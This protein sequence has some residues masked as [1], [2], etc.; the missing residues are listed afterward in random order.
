MAIE[1]SSK[2][3]LYTIIAVILIAVVFGV[4]AWMV[5][6]QRDSLLD[7]KADFVQNQNDLDEK[8]REL[9]QLVQLESKFEAGEVRRNTVLNLIPSSMEQELLINLLVDLADENRVTMNTLSFSESFSN[10]F[11]INSVNIATSITGTH[12]SLKDFIESLE[13]SSRKFRVNSI[14]VQRLEN[15]LENMTLTIE[16][17]YL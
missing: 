14:S 5:L 13:T 16:A 8:K 6:P 10:D 9:N 7:Q 2:Q 15:R 3:N 4:V 17:Y 12:K 1:Q 11:Q